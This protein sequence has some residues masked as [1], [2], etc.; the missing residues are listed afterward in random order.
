MFF[1]RS[2]FSPLLFTLSTWGTPGQGQ[3]PDDHDLMLSISQGDQRALELFYE[4]Y[5]GLVY[6]LLVQMLADQGQAEEATLDTFTRIW[7]QA[8]SYSAS[9]SSVKTWLTRIARNRGIDILRSRRSRPDGNSSLWNDDALEALSAATTPEEYTEKQD[10]RRR[11]K[12]V[13]ASLPENQRAPLALAYLGGYSHSEIAA[14]LE[15][16]LGTIKSRIRQAM[17]VLKNHF[18]EVQ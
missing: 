8:K 13:I 3:G 7:Q 17:M 18:T 6:S 5:K 1:F 4:R 10:M 12:E 16:P 14:R 15:Q 2:L 11:I 9:R